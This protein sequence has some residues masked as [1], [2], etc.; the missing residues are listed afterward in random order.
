MVV[1]KGIAFTKKGYTNN[2]VIGSKC[3]TSLPDLACKIA[4][5]CKEGLII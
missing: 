3:C 5:L 4:K 1:T 2:R